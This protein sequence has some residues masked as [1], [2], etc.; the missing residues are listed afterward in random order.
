[1]IGNEVITNRGVYPPELIV[2]GESIYSRNG[3]S[4]RRI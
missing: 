1:M 4:W 2:P 3:S